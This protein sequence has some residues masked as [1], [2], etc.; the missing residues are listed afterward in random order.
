MFKII[1]FGG[2][3]LQ[4]SKE[5]ELVLRIISEDKNKKVIVVSALKGITDFLIKTLNEALRSEDRVSSLVNQIL[6]RHFEF[7]KN[8]PASV[9]EEVEERL[10]IKIRELKK[11]LLGISY[12]REVTPYLHAQIISYGERLAAVLLAGLLKGRH[13]PALSL[14]ADQIGLLTDDCPFQA[15]A[16]LRET[17][18]NLKQSLLPLL[19]K[20]FIPVVTGFLGRNKRGQT[21]TLGRNGS[22]Y[23][24]TILARVLNADKIEL[25]KDVPGYMTTDPSFEP[26]AWKI[27]FLSYQEAAELSYFGSKIIHPRFFEPLFTHP[28]P[29]EIKHLYYPHQ[30]GTVIINRAPKSNQTIKS[31]AVNQE[32]GLLRL[33][34]QGICFQPGLLRKVAEILGSQEITFYSLLTSQTSLNLIIPKQDMKRVYSLLKTLRFRSLSKI[35]YDDQVSLI[36]LVGEGLLRKQRTLARVFAAVARKGIKVEVGSAGASSLV[37]YFLVKKKDLHRAVAAIHQELFST[38]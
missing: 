32:I 17:E 4:S 30:P 36:G 9:K 8:C 24:A 18:K 16:L 20:N 2:G 25:W 26:K 6:D 21:T 14:E 23:S 28:I 13:L 11:I 29:V 10:K 31:V 34:G 12:I 5:M 38:I 22:D 19:D 33:Q 1:K 3:C 37:Y 7:T 27:D 35:S 15:T